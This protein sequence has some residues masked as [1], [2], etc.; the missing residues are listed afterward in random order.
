MKNPFEKAPENPNSI[1]PE[2]MQRWKVMQQHLGDQ[3]DLGRLQ[4]VVAKIVGERIENSWKA[5]AKDS[6]Q[7]FPEV[8][9]DHAGREITRYSGDIKSAFA[10]WVQ[11]PIRVKLGKAVNFR[12]RTYIEGRVPPDVQRSMWLVSHGFEE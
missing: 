12:G 10:P 1:P 6:G 11:E 7:L 8:T 9:K 3:T 5:W 4:P 2:I